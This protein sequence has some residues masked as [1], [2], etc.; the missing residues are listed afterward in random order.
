MTT[1][2]AFKVKR[3][4]CNKKLVATTLILL[5]SSLGFGQNT[6][7][8][9]R[10]G[11][12]TVEVR[13]DN[14]D[15]VAGVQFSIRGSTKVTLSDFQR[16]ER[17]ENHEWIVASY[18]PND[19]TINVVI[20]G[21]SRLYFPKGQG[22]VARISYRVGDASSTNRIYLTNVMI[23]NPQAESLQVAV[24]NAEWT[25][26]HQFASASSN[27]NVKLGQN[28]P[29]PFNPSTR[30]AY[31][32]TKAGQVLLSVYDITGREVARL[33]DGYQ[34]VGDYSVTWNSKDAVG[35]ILPSGVY[36]ARIQVENE[37]ATMKMILAK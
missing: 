25:V 11:L 24:Q 6:L 20:L 5:A 37:V 13:L 36:F 15:D 16:A 26:G 1:T 9:V 19:S 2:G 34:F 35:G 10:T 8:V 18:Q 14:S 27:P 31:S 29:N 22:S 23:A 30:L 21:S 17:N 3:A 7:S 12:S 33:V 4:G 32:L 28:F